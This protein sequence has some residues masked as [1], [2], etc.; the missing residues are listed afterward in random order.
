MDSLT[1]VVASVALV[2][3]CGKLGGYISW[4]ANKVE[5]FD[6]LVAFRN[7]IDSLSRVLGSI[8]ACFDNPSQATL[9]LAP[10]TGFETEH[11]RNVERSMEDCKKLL[12]KLHGILRSLS[13]AKRGQTSVRRRTKINALELDV[14]ELRQLKQQLTAYRMTMELSLQLIIVYLTPSNLFALN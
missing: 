9:A 6:T 1:I 10:Q 8:S 5:N 2:S 11:W 13:N 14:R 3:T 4:L 12:E 7:E